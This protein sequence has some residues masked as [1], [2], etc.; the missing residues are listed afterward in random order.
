MAS[1]FG[2]TPVF[3]KGDKSDID[4][5]NPPADSVSSLNFSPTSGYLVGS[6]WDNKVRVWEVTQ[7]GASKSV[8]EKEHTQ[9]VLDTCWS[10]DGSKVF[11]AGCDKALMQWD[12]GSNTFQQVGAHDAPIKTC[13][14]VAASNVVLT[15]GWDGKLKYWDLRTPNPAAVVEAG[16]KVYSADVSGPLGVVATANRMIKVY[17]LRNP[18]T[19]M[20]TVESN[21]KFQ[22]R[23]VSCFPEIAN[24]TGAGFAYGSI[25]G[26]VALHFVNEPIESKAHFSFKC[27]RDNPTSTSQPA[28]IYSVNAISFHPKYGTFSTA[29]S[30][31]TYHFWD[32]DSKQ[33]LKNFTTPGTWGDGKPAPISATAFNN[34]GTIFAYACSYDWSQGH[35]QY[36]PDV[37]K[38]NILLHGCQESDVKPRPRTTR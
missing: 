20:R 21:L 26:R 23:V 34:E 25:E 17:D 5:T 9:P 27:H 31:G 22:T 1:G 28:K 36:N 35:S 18:Q 16:E 32:K 12:L 29:G 6:S 2:A 19:T 7:Q 10:Q 24:N 11:S 4:I 37:H 8:A 3:T 33:R 14:Y 13:H 38:P 30:D 15:G